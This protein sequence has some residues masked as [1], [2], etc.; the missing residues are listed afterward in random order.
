MM[1]VDK[2]NGKGYVEVNEHAHES[3]EYASK[4]LAGTALGLGI[5]GL[6][7]SL[8]GNGCGNNILNRLGF[9]CGCGNIDAA[10]QIADN[11]YVERKECADYLAI[12]E[13]Y[14]QGQL[15]NQVARF[16]DRQTLNKEFFDSYAFTRN[17]FD[18]ITTKHNEDAFNLYKAG[19][20]N[21]DALSAEI[22]ELKTE[23]AVLKA[24]RP[25]QD[26][27]I[28]CDICRVAEHADFNLWC[29]TCR[30][31]QG[32]VVLP[33]TPTV[34]GYPSYNPCVQNTSSTPTT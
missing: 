15:A 16:A 10:A 21:K 19:R 20:D 6:A 12:T 23:L 13:K 32:E 11:Q 30:M 4:S 9:G 8:L 28:Q 31:I 33:N 14:Y 7:L 1:L 29:R 3:K 25:Y 27:L 5:G 2:E 22:G 24:T 34:T 18:A 26:A 17:G